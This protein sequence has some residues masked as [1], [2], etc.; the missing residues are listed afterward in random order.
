MAPAYMYFGIGRVLDYIGHSVTE[1]HS[2]TLHHHGMINT[3]I[4]FLY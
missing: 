2:E 3:T 4:A 1:P